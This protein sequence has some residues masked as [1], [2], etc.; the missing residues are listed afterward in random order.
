MC[1]TPGTSRRP[2]K[3]RRGLPADAV[4]L[5]V[6]NLGMI[7]RFTARPIGTTRTVAVRTTDPSRDVTV[8]LSADGVEYAPSGRG[9]PDLVLPAEALR[10]C[11]LRTPGPRPHPGLH[12]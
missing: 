11:G 12:R 3:E 5:V 9:E 1:S 7:A 6:D 10:R 4:P 2:C 8:S